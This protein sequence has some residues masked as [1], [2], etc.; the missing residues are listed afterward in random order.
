MT[1]LELLDR[2]AGYFES[3]EIT[4]ARF[5]AESLTAHVLGKP[6]LA[7]YLEFDRPM[8]EAELDALRPLVK[9]R[10]EGEPLQHIVGTTDFCG[11][12]LECSPEALIP[13]PE[14]EML[15]EWVTD[16]LGNHPG[17]T[18]VDVGTGSGCIALACAAALPGWK[19]LATE[20]SPAALA[21]AR[22]NG[23]RH[24]ELKVEWLEGDLL[25]PI[26][27]PPLA[28]VA[29]LPYLTREEM[30]PLPPEVKNDPVSA[31]EGGEDG[32]DNIRHL[33]ASLAPE[34][35]FCFLEMGI[36]QG[37]AITAL[38]KDAGFSDVSL[39]EDL[40]GRPR[41]AAAQRC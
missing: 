26:S 7:L 33:I 16:T 41:F 30:T 20:K 17:G 24:P 28:V 21:L 6:R 35:T 23:D 12:T 3:K 31:L 22:R 10:A 4:S 29:N 32:L 11:L 36:A 18:L 8:Q 9:R 27:P 2:T 13:R 40:T 15:V 38:F 39:A 5:Q 34:T 19:I 14:T 1:L 25:A 37:D